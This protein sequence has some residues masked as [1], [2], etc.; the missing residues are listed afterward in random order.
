MRAEWACEERDGLVLLRFTLRGDES[1]WGPLQRVRLFEVDLGAEAVEIFRGGAFMPS[2]PAGFYLV[3][4]GQPAPE[5]GVW[6][7]AGFDQ[8]TLACHTLAAAD[9]PATG[10]FIAGFV[11][12][13]RFEGFLV[14][15]T[16]GETVTMSAWCDLEGM[17]LASGQP[18]VLETIALIAAADFPGA[19]RRYAEHLAQRHQARVL[20]APVTGWVDWQYYREEKT[21]ADILRSAA[22]MA[23]LRRQG[24]PLDYVIVDG[25]WCD[26]CSEWLKPCAKFPAGMKALGDRLH[27]DGLRFGLWFAPYLINAGTELARRHPE[28]LVIDRETGRPLYKPRSNVGPAHVLDFSVPAA[29]EWL[30]ETV[31]TMVHDYGIDYLKLDGPA[32]AHYEGGRFHDPAVTRLQQVRWSLEVIR[33]ACGEG[34]VVEGEGVYGPGIGLVE[35]QRIQQDPHPYWY[36]PETGEPMLKENLKNELAG[37]FWHN[38]LWHNHRENVILRDFPSPF[39]TRKR[40]DPNLKEGIL[41]EPEVRFQVTA[42][43]MAGGAMLLGDPVEQLSRNPRRFELL[44]QFLPHY[45]G[46]AAP[47][48]VFRGDGRQPSLYVLPLQ[49]AGEDYTVVA[50][51]N[52]EDQYE[53]FNLDLPAIVGEGEWHAFEFWEQ[54]YL[55][56]AVDQVRVRDVPAH[57]C[58]LVALRR[59]TG[60]PRLVGTNLHLLQGVVGIPAVSARPGAIELTVDHFMQ[61]DRTLWIWHPY[62]R[63]APRVTTNAVDLLVDSRR[64]NLL[65]IH[66]NG[67]AVTSF[68]CEWE[69]TNGVDS[70]SRALLMAGEDGPLERRPMPAAEVS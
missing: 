37:A 9:A 27:A 60:Q 33:E 51:F 3:R 4:A 13:D 36:S 20:A 62:Q 41:S 12:F 42:A 1:C 49:Q 69:G 65:A 26:L 14:F 66:F 32:L 30:R 28:W 21:E 19:L 8:Y 61:R 44:S 54:S 17:S 43:V 52:W 47:L 34:V 40:K 31:R 15:D 7:P 57:G 55:G 5:V 25:G 29:L 46:A 45:P 39:H 63:T 56:M 16:R 6:R 59:H 50:V 35:V 58:K 10:R 2:D 64:P 22:A 23:A 70:T 24:Y 53:D 11:T 68:T 38:R 18:L 48:D 67:R